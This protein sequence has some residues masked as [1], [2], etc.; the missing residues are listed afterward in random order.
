MTFRSLQSCALLRQ[1]VAKRRRKTHLAPADFD[2]LQTRLKRSL[3]PA[4]LSDPRGRAVVQALVLEHL[5][6][7]GFLAEGLKGSRTGAAGEVSFRPRS[8]TANRGMRDAD[9]G[10]LVVQT[11]Y[12]AAQ[13]A[14][15][16][17]SSQLGMSPLARAHAGTELER[18]SIGGRL[19]GRP[20]AAR[21]RGASAG[22]SAPPIKQQGHRAH[23]AT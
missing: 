2:P 5:P 11:D 3:S 8:S 13:Q 1:E 9:K 22:L 7:D 21:V 23:R 19:R 14:A 4:E 18:L 10:G 12:K 15:C 17:S 6:V 16:R 20:R